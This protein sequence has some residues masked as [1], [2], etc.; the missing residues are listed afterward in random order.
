MNR[1]ETFLSRSYQVHCFI[2]AFFL[3]VSKYSIHFH[4]I[5]SIQNQR[6]FV[7][8]TCKFEAR[9]IEAGIFDQVDQDTWMNWN[10]YLLGKWKAIMDW[11]YHLPKP[12][13]PAITLAEMDLDIPHNFDVVVRT[14]D[15]D[16]D[17]S[18]TQ[19]LPAK[20]PIDPPK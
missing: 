18:P 15:I 14:I 19:P 10:T 3:N 8:H 16:K 2:V 4:S 20:P 7:L 1:K 11:H 13:C 5:H 12:L 17:I 9:I 6:L